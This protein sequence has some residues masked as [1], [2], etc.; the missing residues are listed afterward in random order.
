[1]TR[2]E[3]CDAT[4][5]VVSGCSPIS[6]GCRNCYSARLAGTRLRNHPRAAGLAR[7]AEDG[8]YVWTGEVR[9]HE[10]QLDVPLR[11]RKPKRIFVGDRGDLFHPDV[12]D[13]FL[14]RVFATMALCPDH[15]FL[16]LTKR[17]ERAKKY[18]TDDGVCGRI[19]N[20]AC[21]M[22]DNDWFVVGGISESNQIDGKYHETGWP[23]PNVWLGVSVEDQATAEER[24]PYLLETPA[25]LRF[26]SCE[27]LLGMV[28]LTRINVTAEWRN[29]A[30]MNSL[31]GEVWLPGNCGESSRTFRDLPH[32]DW[33][34]VG[35][36]S[37]P[38]ARPM[39][40]DW[41]RSLRDQCVRAGVPLHF[42]QW[43][44]WQT[45]YDRDQDD[46]DWRRCPRPD[47]KTTRYLN[48]AG[49][50]GFHG[51]RV[52]FVR[53]VGKKRSGRLLDGQ[54]HNNIPKVSP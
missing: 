52:V 31:K 28:N 50:H 5:Q 34:I 51:E 29:T 23:L 49:G 11:W 54:L 8:R 16:L 41:A 42:K 39:H 38:H 37:G 15:T 36:E 30:E 7:Q 40:P 20:E 9:C 10:D 35:G 53:R 24:I 18:L 48:L 45:V 12:P 46:P 4:W 14:D 2:I 32:L 3:W 27:P 19:H 1:M 17:V 21:Q 33:V 6:E 25:A 44:E 43:G 22:T 47:E 13:D 26:L